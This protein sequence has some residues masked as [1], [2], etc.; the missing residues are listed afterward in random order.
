MTD[1]ASSTERRATSE[2]ASVLVVEDDAVLAMALS[3]G[4]RQRGLDVV[5]P[6]LSYR[7]ALLEISRH[8]PGLAVMDIDLGGGDLRPG[9]EGERLLAILT[10]LGCRCVIYSGHSEL[11]PIIAGYFS[12]AVLI[13]KPAGV[14]RVVEALLESGG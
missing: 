12:E 13:A 10:E 14:E 9:H 3:G 1:G 11:F 4:L 2:G 8:R 7:Q 5:G 6:C